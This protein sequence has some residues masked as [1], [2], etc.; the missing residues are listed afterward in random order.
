[1]SGV[2]GENV[3]RLMKKIFSSPVDLLQKVKKDKE[4]LELALLNWDEIQIQETL[5]N[6]SVSSYHL[7]DW[8]KVYYPSLKSH[9]YALL[10][11]NKYIGACRD[12]CNASKH[13]ELDLTAGAY[14]N[15]PPVI[16]DVDQSPTGS[17]VA[18]S[19]PSYRL[20]IQFKD[21]NSIA[22][23]ELI[24]KAFDGWEKFFDDHKITS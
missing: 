11:N 16:C 22:T 13:V 2:Y 12:L 1:M 10:N 6:F 9:V 24:Q 3:M 18:S 7:V 14:G 17:T 4:K 23:E 5:F 21:G 15:H 8:V 20:K 19:F